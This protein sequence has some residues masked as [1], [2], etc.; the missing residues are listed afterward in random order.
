MRSCDLVVSRWGARFLGRRFPCATGRGGIGEKRCEGDGVTPEGCH[1]IETVYA[2][3]ETVWKRYGNR[4]ATCHIGIQPIRP[5]DLWSDDPAD[6]NYNR[7]VRPPHRF[8]HEAM[9]R[10]DGLYN[11]VAVLDWNRHP[12]VP[13]RGSAIFL[14]VWRRPRHPTVGCIAFAPAD[15]GWILAHWQRHSRV[16]VQGR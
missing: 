12:V 6:P 4:M 16:M 9:Q 7:L 8:S 5:F 2:R 3:M 1:R 13:G 15:L 11:L 14:H 10:A